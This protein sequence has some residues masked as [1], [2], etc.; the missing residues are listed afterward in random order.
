MSVGR[1]RAAQDQKEGAGAPPSGFSEAAGPPVEF[2]QRSGASDMPG[3]G[4]TALAAE[5]AEPPAGAGPDGAGAQTTGYFGGG[6]LPARGMTPE[7]R[8]ERNARKRRTHA[9]SGSPAVGTS[10]KKAG[11]PLCTL[12]LGIKPHAAVAREATRCAAAAHDR[13]V[14]K[15][16]RP[17]LFLL[18]PNRLAAQGADRCAITLDVRLGVEYESGPP[19]WVVSALCASVNVC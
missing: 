4:A 9:G 10:S 14:Q 15:H 11:V 16:H 1:E 7:E 17:S 8:R 18:R 6:W 13:P 5:G 3:C 19:F 12:L 2:I